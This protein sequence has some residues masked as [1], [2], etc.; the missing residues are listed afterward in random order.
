MNLKLLKRRKS[1]KSK[2]NKLQNRPDKQ[3]SRLNSKLSLRPNKKPRSVKENR[4][5]NKRQLS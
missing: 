3:K 4:K 2:P 5:L 1:N